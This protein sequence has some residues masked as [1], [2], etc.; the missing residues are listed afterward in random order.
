MSRDPFFNFD[1][2][3]YISGTAEASRQI[4]YA[5]RIISSA[6][7]SMTD[8]SLMGVVSYVTHF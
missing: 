3:N 6:W 8:Y 2:R 7:L 4:L 1:A 5:G